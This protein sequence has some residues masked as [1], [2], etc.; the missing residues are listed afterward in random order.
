MALNPRTLFRAA[1]L[2]NGLVAVGFFFA[3][4]LVGR[5]LKL[6]P[7]PQPALFVMII[8]LCI[9]IFGWGYWIIAGDAVRFRPF[10]LQAA[11]GKLSVVVTLAF[12]IGLGMA[13]VG[14]AG[15]AA[16]D[17]IFSLLFLAYL[18]QSKG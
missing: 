10:I 3:A 14:Y 4:P 17:L 15:L 2:F 5:L 8:A 16:A 12:S 18:R 6:S 13:S 9:A 7:A 11:V 1:A